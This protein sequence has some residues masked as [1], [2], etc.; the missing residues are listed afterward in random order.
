MAI[1]LEGTW[2]YVNSFGISCRAFVIENGVLTEYLFS[3]QS[4][5]P[6]SIDYLPS[7][8]KIVAGDYSIIVKYDE[9]SDKEQKL[10][11]EYNGNKYVQG[12]IYSLGRNPY[13][14]SYEQDMTGA[15]K[16]AEKYINNVW[17]KQDNIF[18]ISLTGDG[19]CN[20]NWYYFDCEVTYD[21]GTERNGTV[22]VVMNDDGSF[23]ARGLDLD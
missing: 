23:E 10:C 1:E 16:E 3:D 12:S 17:D 6:K 5:S 4:L 7:R 22:S 9:D 15:R 19:R 21:N 11:L 13:S 20:G 8:G 18:F 14:D 2:V